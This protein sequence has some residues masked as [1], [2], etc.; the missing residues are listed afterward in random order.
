MALFNKEPRQVREF[1]KSGIHF[2]ELELQTRSAKNNAKK[3]LWN[4]LLIFILLFAQNGFIISAFDLPVFMPAL[5]LTFAIVSLYLAFLYLN[6]TTYNL[7]YI[8]LPFLVI[9]VALTMYQVANSGFSAI[10]NI[11]I[12]KVDEQY[13]LTN[14]REYNEYY[15]NRQISVTVCLMLISIMAGILLNMVISRRRSI[16]WILLSSLLVIEA[17]I[18]LNNDD[19]SYFYLALL[20]FGVLLYRITL[21]NDN[22]EFIYKKHYRIYTSHKTSINLHRNSVSKILALVSAVTFAIAAI[23]LTVILTSGMSQVYLESGSKTKDKTDTVVKNLAAY[24]FAYYFNNGNTGNGGIDNGKVGGT[25]TVIITG[26]NYL[27]LDFVPYSMEEMYIPNYI[28]SRYDSISTTW[29]KDNTS[30]YA[31]YLTNLYVYGILGRE[32]DGNYYIN[33]DMLDDTY[34][35]TWYMLASRYLLECEKSS[36]YDFRIKN[37]NSSSTN[38]DAYYRDKNNT[39][40]YIS[41]APGSS[42]IIEDV[43]PNLLELDQLDTFIEDTTE[44]MEELG[45]EVDVPNTSLIDLATYL[46]YANN[47]GN[48]QLQK[49]LLNVIEDNDFTFSSLTSKIN[50]SEIIDEL[51]N[52]DVNE[53]NKVLDD[54]L[55][56]MDTQKL[57]KE[58]IKIINELQEYYSKDFIYT[59]SPGD[60]MYGYDPNIWF[61][62]ENK[63]G[64]CVYFASSATLL[65]KQLGVPAR[66]V[67][68]YALDIMDL[69]DATRVETIYGEDED[70]TRI[71]QNLDE[72]N[73]D[74]SYIYDGYN[75]LGLTGSDIVEVDLTDG[76]A[77]AWVEVYIYGYGWIPVE[78]TLAS[79]DPA[80]EGSGSSIL[81]N[82][83]NS[84][85]NLFSGDALNDATQA[86]ASEESKQLIEDSF[87]N[88]II[89]ALALF[90]G[91][92]LVIYLKKNLKLYYVAPEKRVVNQYRDLTT[93]IKYVIKKKALK[94]VAYADVAENLDKTPVSHKKFGALTIDCLNLDSD[95]VKE[96]INDVVNFNYSFDDNYKQ[97][98]T[99]KRITN[100]YKKL[101]KLLKGMMPWYK[102]L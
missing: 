43:Y 28:A 36:C 17:G 54:A 87:R 60:V 38:F 62:K 42:A 52:G 50:N 44:E 1:K 98:E 82:L 40:D 3:C 63:K 59:L 21:Q 26:T 32:N 56:L 66:Y 92:L 101:R 2:Q 35:M 48:V 72:V 6:T 94:D 46:A 23:V 55:A 5:I 27:T 4:A 22:A 73:V 49:E 81:S 39:S 41:I 57:V 9:G 19:F 76:N 95:L 11:V 7:G 96:Y 45:N 13:V 64:Y 90:F 47:N 58:E 67:E 80:E 77:H 91:F 31:N 84:G 102:K 97:A 33:Y 89:A 70:D 71:I 14:I 85:S 29:E 25:S 15:A 88:L 74:P 34:S 12:N 86:M 8:A 69:S 79:E 37:L 18:Y 24:G 65:L 51:E 10:I 61:L 100:E 99:V 30:D 16:F 68:G 78:F 83:I 75:D 93:K 53:T 20:I